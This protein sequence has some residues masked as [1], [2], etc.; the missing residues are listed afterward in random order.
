[1]EK[2]RNHLFSLVKTDFNN[3]QPN[4]YKD[5]MIKFVDLSEEERETFLNDINAQVMRKIRNEEMFNGSNIEFN[6]IDIDID[7][8]EFIISIKYEERVFINNNGKYEQISIPKYRVISIEIDELYYNSDSFTSIP[9][10]NPCINISDFRYHKMKF[11][12]SIMCRIIDND[13][14]NVIFNKD[15]EIP[16]QYP[17]YK[18]YTKETKLIEITDNDS[19]NE[20]FHFGYEN[21]LYYELQ[22]A[23]KQNL[24]KYA[25]ETVSDL[26]YKSIIKLI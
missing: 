9:K 16:N 4:I 5:T 8:S 12:S 2:I 26:I 13:N 10:D 21:L 24:I 20:A 22:F 7:K 19:K 17:Y 11:H 14:M 23:Q 1:M 15:K 6:I 25:I 3:L 18:R